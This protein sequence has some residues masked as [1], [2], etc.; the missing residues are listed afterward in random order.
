MI[1]K[2]KNAEALLEKE[3][4][5]MRESHHRIKNNLQLVNSILDLQSR[6]MKDPAVKKAFM[7]SRQRI[8]AISFAH[9]RL[10][11]ND[12]VEKLNLKSFLFD[13]IQSI[14]QSSLDEHS[15]IKIVPRLDEMDI[16]TEKAIP[17]GLIM[18][19]LLT[20]AIKYAF[21]SHQ[22]GTIVV[23]L[24]RQ[25]NQVELVIGDNGAGMK[26]NTEGTGFGHQL[27]KSMVRQLKA[28]YSLSLTP[29][30]KHVFLIPL[31]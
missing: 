8:Q 26:E 5:M 9:Q 2:K 14:Q 29:G 15:H 19:E 10:Y 4:L 30:V 18:N 12:T 25:S 1:E 22:G 3:K 11:G 20:N 13:L 6:N 28:E 31:S 16:S 17:I 24:T 23:N 27:V 7:E 21:N